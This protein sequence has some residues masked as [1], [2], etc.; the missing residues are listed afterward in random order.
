MHLTPEKGMGE[1][2]GLG[3]ESLDHHAVLKKSWPTE[4]QKQ[5]FPGRG[6]FPGRG[7]LH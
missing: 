7:D 3:R 2:A 5:A 1:K 6:T 4:T